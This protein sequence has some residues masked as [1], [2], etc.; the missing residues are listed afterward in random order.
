MSQDNTHARDFHPGLGCPAACPRGRPAY[1]GRRWRQARFP[2][3]YISWNVRGLRDER[4]QGIVGR[5]LREWG[6]EVVCLQETMMA[7]YE[8]LFWTALGV[9]CGNA[10]VAIAASGRSSGILLAWKAKIFDQVSTW[11]GRHVVAACLLNRRSGTAVVVAAVYGPTVQALQ[12][13]LWEDIRLLYGVYP[14]TQILIGGDFNVTLRADNRPNGGGG[15]DPGSSQF[16]DIIALLSMAEMGPANCQFTWRG[17]TTQSRLDCFLCSPEWLAAFPLVEVSALS[18]PLSDHT[19]ICWSSMVGLAKPTY[20]KLNRSWLRDENLKR[21][22]LAWWVRHQ[23][24][25]SSS[26]PLRTSSTNPY[27]PNT[28]P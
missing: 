2:M 4:K 10:H 19:L 16:W 5:H 6:A 11:K 24:E 23:A 20:F 12:E 18:R 8:Q 25:G 27:G 22:I 26:L 28:S 15:R 13:E 21:D 9:G 14:E 3:R 7:H 17:P 1:G